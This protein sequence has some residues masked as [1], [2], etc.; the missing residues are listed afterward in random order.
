ML[1]QSAFSRDLCN[2]A[3]NRTFVYEVTG[4]HDNDLNAKRDRQIRT[5]G[6][7][8]IQVPF[9]RM[10]ATMQR[11]INLG[12][13]IVNIRPLSENVSSSAESAHE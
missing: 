7:T 9:Y 12:G 5:G 2:T 3:D 4:I 6:I 8:F 11:V 13:K 1:G 10:S